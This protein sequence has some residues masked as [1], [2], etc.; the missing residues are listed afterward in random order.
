MNLKTNMDTIAT[1]TIS[2]TWNA[3][4]IKEINN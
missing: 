3:F 2:T 4:I 1:H